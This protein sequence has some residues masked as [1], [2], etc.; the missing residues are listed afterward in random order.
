M[1]DQKIEVSVRGK[2]RSLPTISIGPKVVV[3]I[4]GSLIRTGRVHDEFWL[5]TK[6][7]PEPT[8]I[9]ARLEQDRSK[10]DI[11]TFAQKLP[12]VSPRYAYHLDWDNVAVA[13]FESYDE[14]YQ[15]KINRGA[16]YSIRKAA[17]E[18][19]R[20]EIVSFT[21]DFVRGISSIYDESATRQGRRFWHFGKTFEEVKR[22]NMSYLDRSVFIGA[23]HNDELIGFIKIVFDEKVGLMM[24]IL[25]KIRHFEKCTTNALLSHAV[26]TCESRG[27]KY[28]TYGYYI[29]GNKDQSSLIDFK[30]NNGFEKVDVPRYYVPLSRK[31]KVF[32][33]LAILGGYR[34]FIPPFVWSCAA[35]LRAKWNGAR[36]R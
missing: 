27:V 10:P 25:S 6:D 34:K 4:T 18:N 32:M 8:E 19:V 14:W 23:Y 16:R 31:G 7:I 20:T 33:G 35:E 22:D 26:K 2:L 9:L 15:A 24:Q 13:K 36:S 11:F 5:A 29:Y 28:L 21:D 1:Q 17:R 3:E 30:R 12:D